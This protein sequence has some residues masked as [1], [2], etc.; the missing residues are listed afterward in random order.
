ML[1]IYRTGDL[2]GFYYDQGRDAKEIWE[3]IYKGDFFL[4]GPTTGIAGIFRG[5]FYYYLIAPVYWL[6]AG[7]PVWPAN[8]VSLT[9]VAAALVVFFLGKIAQSRVTGLF[10]VI[11]SSISMYLVLSSRWFSNPTPMFLFSVLLLLFMFMVIDGKRWAW[12]P[13]SFVAGISIFHFGSSGEFFYFPALLIF[14]IWQ[15]LNDVNRPT[16]RITALSAGLFA[17]TVLPLVAFDFKNE[18]LLSRNLSQ[19]L[20]EKESFKPDFA[21]VIADRASLYYHT[22]GAEIF[23]TLSKSANILL[24]ALSISFIIFI[25]YFLKNRKI[26]ATM[27]LLISPIIG[28]T[29][30]QGNEGNVYGYY[31]TGYYLVFVLMVSYVLGRL[32]TYSAGKLFVLIFFAVFITANLPPLWFKL[33]NEDLDP[34]TIN[35]KNQRQAIEWIYKDASGH[36][37]NFDVYV[38]PVIPHAYDYLFIWY[39]SSLGYSGLVD[40]HLPLLYTLYEI[41]PPHPE[42]INAWHERQS[43]I[44]IVEYEQNF[45]GVTV[46]RRTRRE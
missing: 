15:V 3:L 37:F 14:F 25:P 7:N 42:R 31:L 20:F 1:R 40:E 34:G 36:S 35:F 26:I 39:E 9:T 13:L 27:L 23:P 44:G 11:I 12:A 30:F 43:G 18:Q 16:Y 2:L 22:F 17:L 29:F 6:S 21:A 45:G 19:F 38:P 8:F 4:I 33:N 24:G 46:Q 10:A 5:P 41:D 28:L 32:W